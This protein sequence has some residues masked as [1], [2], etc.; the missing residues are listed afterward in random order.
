MDDGPIV[1]DEDNHHHLFVEHRD[2][3]PSE[4]EV[5]EALTS[6][7]REEK[8]D[9]EREGL[10]AVLALTTTGRW[11]FVVWIEHGGGRYPI[12]S[13]YADTRTRRRYGR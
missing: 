2:P 3:R 4:P 6:P 12:H 8:P 13:R 10:I 11:V 5:V 1:W 7:A 9:P